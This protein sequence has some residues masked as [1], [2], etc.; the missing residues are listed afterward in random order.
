MK[1]TTTAI[2]EDRPLTLKDYTALVTDAMVR[3]GWTAVNSARVARE[4]RD[5]AATFEVGDVLE[6]QDE[7]VAVRR[8]T[9][10]RGRRRPSL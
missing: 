6:R 3:A 8:A 5:L 7:E 2:V 1:S 9:R 10:V 4:L